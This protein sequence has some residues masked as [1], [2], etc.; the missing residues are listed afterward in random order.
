MARTLYA[1]AGCA[2]AAAFLQNVN[3][4]LVAEGW[5]IDKYVTGESGELYFHNTA[6][7][8]FSMTAKSSIRTVEE[9]GWRHICICGNTGFDAALGWHEQPG[10][11]TP[12]MTIPDVG[13]GPAEGHIAYSRSYYGKLVGWWFAPPVDQYIVCGPDDIFIYSVGEGYSVLGSELAGVNTLCLNMCLGEIERYSTSFPDASS[14]QYLVSD[15]LTGYIEIYG[16]ES[17]CLTGGLFGRYLFNYENDLVQERG[18][19]GFV[20]N[21]GFLWRGANHWNDVRLSHVYDPWWSFGR[22]GDYF[23]LLDHHRDNRCFELDDLLGWNPTVDRATLW[24][25]VASINEMDGANACNYPIGNMPYYAVE[26]P[27][28]IQP[29]ES[30]SIG[31][32]EFICFPHLFTDSTFGS[33]IRMD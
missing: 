16:R 2:S 29:G 10:C 33:A 14:G 25:V 23:P 24:P 8:Y 13:Y 27:H 7:R 11:F 20:E 22:G 17:E 4:A 12:S 26:L 1:H 19:M 5:T 28:P 18:S 32:K 9:P 21:S 30:L 31:S 6:G 3:D 15:A